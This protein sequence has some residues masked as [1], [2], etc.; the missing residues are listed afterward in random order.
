M[1][2]YRGAADAITGAVQMQQVVERDNRQGAEPLSMR[3]GISVGDATFDDDD[4]YG[5]P[6]TEA[7]RLC[8]AATGGQI[9]VASIVRTLAG[10]RAEHEL[11]PIGPLDLKGFSDPVEAVEVRWE[12]SPL[13][14]V[15]AP[16]PLPGSL[17]RQDA[18]AFV[19]RE[20]ETELVL[21]AWKETTAGGRRVVLVAGEP[22]IGK[23]R[24]TSEVARI[25]HDQGAVVLWGGCEE[26]LGVPYQPVAEAL[27][28]LAHSLPTDQLTAV[29][30]PWGPELTRLVSDLPRLVPDLGEPVPGDADTERFRLFE[31][32]VDVLVNVS[33]ERPL[34]VVLDDLHWAAKPTLLLL[35]HVA[36]STRPMRVLIAATYRD[37]DL[38][39]RD[40]LAEA[41]ADFRRT[42][43]VQRVSLTGLNVTEV[44]AF[45]EAAAGHELD[46]RALL[47]AEALHKE[48]EGNPFFIGEVLLHL[49]ESGALVQR[50]GR[51]ASDLSLAEVGLPDGV[52]EVIGRRLSRLSERANEV[53]SVAAVIGRDFGL[54][55]LISVHS[56]GEDEVLEALE[57]AERVGLVRPT[58]DRV[59]RYT[60]AHALVR[61]ALYDDLSTSRRLR[62]H[63][64]VGRALEGQGDSADGSA[65]L[66]H[67]F[68][69]CAAL[70]EVDRAIDYSRRAAE[71]A[72]GDLAYEEAALHYERALGVLRRSDRRDPV[73]ECDLLLGQGNAYSRG[74]DPRDRPT[75]LEAA[76]LARG[77]GDARRLAIA[78]IELTSNRWW[79]GPMTLNTVGRRGPGADVTT[80]TDLLDE[81]LTL[82][83]A[84]D[85]RARARALAARAVNETHASGDQVRRRALSEEA[86]AM[87]RR[88]GDK[89]LLR[90]ILLEQWTSWQDTSRQDW[91]DE[92]MAVQ[93]ELV[94]LANGQDDADHFFG[95][96]MRSSCHL[97]S[98]Q[99]ADAEHDLTVAIEL[100]QRLRDPVD[101]VVDDVQDR[102]APDPARSARSGRTRDPRGGDLRD[103]PRV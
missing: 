99:R 16:V 65:E 45:M 18:F 56:G 34:L 53:L 26:E 85:S 36:R 84:V 76:L 83:P 48:T 17:A 101:D 66:A 73:V 42:P 33:G 58:S 91:L 71:R 79:P 70:G 14:S 5:R 37:T 62:L 32:V 23:T 2:T 68:A 30:G 87:A 98:G 80:V 86:L 9:L 40:P 41:L 92:A 77:L 97:T 43:D 89:D 19:G 64:E 52:R 29:L 61:S 67:H 12:P 78:A 63:R 74:R 11:V 21:R 49:V 95:L 51:W 24:L 35:L 75:L 20:R 38:D 72:I 7:H 54:S 50:D 22:G 13:D 100:A 82:L 46:E 10:S 93:N 88:L 4:W 103:R 44:T 47:L 81:A 94:E 90:K 8:A 69:E 60:F 6:V 102:G 96:W 39:R 55:L 15:P 27:T 28:H 59:G 31:A 1:V 57:R 25:A 3:V